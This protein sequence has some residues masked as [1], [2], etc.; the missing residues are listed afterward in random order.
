[1]EN[2]TESETAE[3][4][5]DAL[6]KRERNEIELILD[7]LINYYDVVKKNVCDYIPKIIITLLVKK[8]ISQCDRVLISKLYKEDN[9]DKLFELKTE[10]ENDLQ[11]IRDQIRD[12]QGL[13]K[14]IA[15]IE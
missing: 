10:Q 3:F 9:L 11:K 6:T 8:T 14:M 15:R 5:F 12:I 7:M 1:M 4:D 2:I 13:L